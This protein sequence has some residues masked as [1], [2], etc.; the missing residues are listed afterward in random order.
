MINS[1]PKYPPPA[2]ESYHYPHSGSLYGQMFICVT[3]NSTSFHD[4]G[5]QLRYDDPHIH[6]ANLPDDMAVQFQDMQL[7]LRGKHLFCIQRYF[8]KFYHLFLKILLCNVF[9]KFET[10]YGRGYNFETGNVRYN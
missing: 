6:D 9:A 1:V 2:N 4:I 8:M 10:F 5:R 3:F 7:L